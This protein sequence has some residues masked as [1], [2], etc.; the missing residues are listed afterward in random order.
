MIKQLTHVTIYVK[1]QDEAKKFY[2]DT[3]GFKVVV[4]DSKTIP[5]YRWL[6][7]A[8]QGQAGLQIVLALPMDAQQTAELGKQGTWV[9]SS[10]NIQE[11]YRTL[12][13]RGVKTN[14]EPQQNP[15]G[16]DFVFEDLYG[17]TYDL[18]QSLN[19]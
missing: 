9:L 4:D 16:I 5:G 12:K 11:D 15:Y 14:S 2:V 17:N 18:V 6:T 13:S 19:A 10:D 7:V 3:L 8:P 1:N